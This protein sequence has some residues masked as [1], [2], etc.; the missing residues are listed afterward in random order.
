MRLVPAALLLS[1][2]ALPAAAQSSPEV[3]AA[4]RLEDPMVQEGLAMAV[5]SMAAIVLD[6][7]VGPLASLLDPGSGVRPSDTLRD[8]QRRRDPDFEARLHDDT[9]RAV[10]TAGAA[11]SGAA[12]MSSELQRTAKR[13]EAALAPL[14]GV[15]GSAD[16]EYVPADEVDEDY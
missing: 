13:L 8:V 16:R 14:A 12:A 2:I 4:R 7:R 6:T 10:A 15:I 5:A 3:D 1:A 11:A 9:R